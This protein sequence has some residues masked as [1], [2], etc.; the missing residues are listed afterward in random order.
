MW[1]VFWKKKLNIPPKIL[2]IQP[3]NPTFS[4]T[5]CELW[6]LLSC[7]P[8]I[9]VEQSFYLQRVRFQVLFFS[10]PIKVQVALTHFDLQNVHTTENI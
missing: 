6:R 2:I 7:V 9:R 10:L 3:F 8:M 4:I 1:Y 5:D